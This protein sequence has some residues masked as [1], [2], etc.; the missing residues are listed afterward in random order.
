MDQPGKYEGVGWMTHRDQVGREAKVKQRTRVVLKVG[1]HLQR[2]TP[3][4]SEAA[5]H[6]HK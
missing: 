2:A 1:R 5:G 4:F 6:P 3:T